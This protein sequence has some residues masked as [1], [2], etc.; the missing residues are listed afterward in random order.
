MSSL[1]VN[2]EVEE[3]EITYQIKDQENQQQHQRVIRLKCFD[4]STIEVE[5]TLARMSRLLRRKL[6]NLKYVKQ[7]DQNANLIVYQEDRNINIHIY[8]II[9]LI[10]DQWCRHHLNNDVNSLSFFF[11]SILCY[12][13]LLLYY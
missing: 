6:D 7:E 1:K 9:R 12:Y 10:F 4:N 8:L 3:R 11:F 5:E 13:L 2:T